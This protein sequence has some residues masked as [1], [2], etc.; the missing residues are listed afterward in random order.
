M[1]RIRV[2]I[3]TTGQEGTV[4]QSEF[5]P[6]IY[7]SLE[8]PMVSKGAFG[9]AASQVNLAGTNNPQPTTKKNR[10]LLASILPILGAVGGG[11]AGS[12]LGPG[13]I[14]AGGAIGGGLGETAAQRISGENLNAKKIALN[15]AI[16]GVP[17]GRGANILSK[18]LLPGATVGGL[19]GLTQDNATPESVA[20]SAGLGAGG[21]GVLS[22]VLPGAASLLG[23]VSPKLEGSAKAIEA[24]TRQIRVK[25]SIYGAGQEKAI[26]TTLTK[27]KVKGSPQQ[28]YDALQPTMQKIEGRVQEVIKENP[29]VSVS[30]AD[31]QQSFIDSLKSSVRSGELTEKQAIKEVDKYLNDLIKASGG[32]GKFTNISLERLRNLK[33]LVNEDYGPVHEIQVRGGALNPRQKVIEAS[34]SSLDNAVKNASPEMKV[35]LK[36]ES[37]IF[38]SARSLSAAR[39]NPP[40]LR[41]AGTSI[42]APLVERGKSTLVDVLREAG[43]KT[44]RFSN[45]GSTISN[46]AENPLMQQLLGQAGGR[47]NLSGGLPQVGGNINNEPNNDNNQQQDKNIQLDNSISQDV[48]QGEE[49]TVD[50]GGN[51]VTESQLKQAIINDYAL[52]GGKNKTALEA[53]QKQAF[54]ELDKKAKKYSE[55]DKKFLLAKNEATKAFNTLNKGNVTTGKVAAASSNLSQF[56]GTQDEDTTAFKAQLAT[57]RTAARNALLGAS[58]SDQELESFLDAIFSYSNEPR[59]IKQKLKTFIESMQDYE[60][61]I[62]GTGSGIED[63]FQQSTQ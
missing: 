62:A 25:P 54:P 30:R 8:T 45:A 41:I 31:I 36:D 2:K 9:D 40:T 42:P 50:L 47:I 26:E 24:G 58:M 23:K 17:F 53:I 51:T 12:P 60:N 1:A 19:G 49:R 55:G 21:A 33:K 52:N 29:N 5:D 15:A 38:K 44:E 20:L 34:W 46:T 27:Y 28:Q 14:I 59:I 16:G 11:I 61:S 7:T 10:S 3:N 39:S 22:K 43:N 56:L 32:K 13:G 48:N 4:E 63:L 6:S 57:A 35:L 18:V 37:N